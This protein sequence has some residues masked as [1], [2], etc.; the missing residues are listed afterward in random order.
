MPEEEEHNLSDAIAQNAAG[1]AK[2]SGDEGSVEQYSLSEMI[3]ADRYL[4]SKNAARNSG[5]PFRLTKLIPP[6]CD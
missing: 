1:P 4:A 3:E 5:F 2:A 6:N